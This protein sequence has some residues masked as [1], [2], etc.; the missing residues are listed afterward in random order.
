MSPPTRRV[1]PRPRRAASSMLVSPSPRFS[2]PCPALDGGRFEAVSSLRQGPSSIPSLS[3]RTT[4]ALT[5]RPLSRPRLASSLNARATA[6]ATPRV[7]SS[8]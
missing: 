3:S 2:P 4:R 6:F 8:G 1:C 5:S 7:V